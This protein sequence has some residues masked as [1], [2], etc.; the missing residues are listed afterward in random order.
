MDIFRKKHDDEALG[1]NW[2]KSFLKRHPDLQTLKVR[3]RDKARADA[4]DHD[5]IR[6]WFDLF[7][8]VQS[9]YGIGYDDIYNMDEKGCMMGISGS[10]TVIVPKTKSA[11]HIVQPGNRDWASII[12]CCNTT[13]FVLPPFFIFKGQRLQQAWYD[14]LDDPN[15]VLSVSENGWT[16]CEFAMKWLE[17]F[18]VST[19]PRRRGT[20]RLLILDGHVS[21]VS[22]EFIEYCEA[23]EI[24][25]LCLPAHTTHLLQPLDVG[26]FSSVGQLY[27]EQVIQHSPFGVVRVTV[28]DFLRYYQAAR[29]N[30]INNIA[31]AWRGAGLHPFNPELLL[32]DLRPKT[33]PR[34]TLTDNQGRQV[35]ID[36]HEHL[37][38][39]IN[40]L[41]AEVF[42]QHAVNTPLRDAISFLRST[43][44]T[45]LAEKTATDLINTELISTSKK[46]TR[47]SKK[48]HGKARVLT[49]DEARAERAVQEAKQEA[50]EQAKAQR[51][52]HREA[53]NFIKLVWT[54]YKMKPV[55]FC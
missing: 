44:L 51:A 9:Q 39:R 32:A 38:D 26:I 8:A 24:I 6:E 50:Q 35:T 54:E 43:S 41:V 45:A 28:F 1:L 25:S 4:A 16:D 30:M 12:E 7:F 11:A 10:Q 15:A 37:E 33:P 31:G 47:N 14:A 18:D 20:H 13:N 46:T 27:R 53:V 36:A 22:L 34:I 17:H 29:R 19:R 40:S 48:H 21:H 52:E 23:H 2:Y 55:I 3:A 42:L 5:T 49:G